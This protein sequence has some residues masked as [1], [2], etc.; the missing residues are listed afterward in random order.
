M[1][2]I[3]TISQNQKAGLSGVGAYAPLNT[4]SDAPRRTPCFQL[5]PTVRSMLVLIFAEIIQL[6]E[7]HY[8]PG[9]L[10]SLNVQVIVNVVNHQT[11]D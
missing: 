1:R 11:E 8:A 9:S 2:I 7:D 6:T 5:L 10:Q 3:T 4:E